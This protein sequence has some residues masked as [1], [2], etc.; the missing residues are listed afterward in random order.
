MWTEVE[1]PIGPIRL[2]ARGT[3]LTGVFML[4]HKYGPAGLS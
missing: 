2:T 1:S 3:A 4:K